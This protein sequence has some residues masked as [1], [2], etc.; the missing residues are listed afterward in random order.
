MIKCPSTRVC[1]AKFN[2][3]GTG[4]WS[5]ERKTVSMIAVKLNYLDQE[6][7]EWFGEIQVLIDPATWN[8]SE[9]GL[10]YTDPQFIFELRDFLYRIGFSK[11]AVADVTYSEQGMQG[12]DF[13]SFD[14][15]DIFLREADKNNYFT[16]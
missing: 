9:D 3:A 13:V 11:E 16:R 7:S 15:G 5:I 1:F 12:D 6:D 10:I 14:A 8:C 4:L 2:T